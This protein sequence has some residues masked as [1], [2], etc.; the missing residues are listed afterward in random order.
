MSV[1]Q[2]AAAA[3]AAAIAAAAPVQA[4]YESQH[5]A[6]HKLVLH[7][8]CNTSF[9]TQSNGNRRKVSLS[10]TNNPQSLLHFS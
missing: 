8:F 6:H 2:A 1:D 3:N 7:T 4:L 9:H 10:P 5:P